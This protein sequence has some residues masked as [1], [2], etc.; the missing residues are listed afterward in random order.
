MAPL[1]PGVRSGP[2]GRASFT[3][4]CGPC[5]DTSPEMGL[6]GVC[7]S[8]GSPAATAA[9]GQQPP[10]PGTC[11][12]T[13]PEGLCFFH[14]LAGGPGISVSC[15]VKLAVGVGRPRVCSGRKGENR[16]PP[17]GPSERRGIIGEPT[18]STATTAPPPTAWRPYSARSL[19]WLGHALGRVEYPCS[20]PQERG[21]G[22]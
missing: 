14:F 7:L 17:W 4:R 12:L 8:S 6:A 11:L 21:G 18:P 2:H 15:S 5:W 22:P 9:P 10:V 3:G 1:C 16:A 19:L 13:L 20:L